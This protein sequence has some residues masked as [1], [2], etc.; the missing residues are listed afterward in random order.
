MKKAH[1]YHLPFSDWMDGSKRP[2][3]FA[4]TRDTDEVSD[5]SV[6]S[7]HT[8][9]L[10]IGSDAESDLSLSDDDIPAPCYSPHGISDGICKTVFK[11]NI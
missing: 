2:Y 5:V 3:K 6:S 4:W 7:V 1:K 8:S 10:S 11:I 9:D